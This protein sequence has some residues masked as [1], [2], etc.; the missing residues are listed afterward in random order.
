MN[1]EE[2]DLNTV[3]GVS[4]VRHADGH[5]YN[6]FQHISED[7]NGDLPPVMVY[8]DSNDSYYRPVE[9]FFGTTFDMSSREVERFIP[10]AGDGTFL[11]NLTLEGVPVVTRVTQYDLADSLSQ[12]IHE[13]SGVEVALVPDILDEYA[14]S[15]EIEYAVQ[16]TSEEGV[17]DDDQET[18]LN[19]LFNIDIWADSDDLTKQILRAFNLK[20]EVAKF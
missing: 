7:G 6:L 18:L 11:W 16:L 1:M 17:P 15:Y 3:K 12:I 5:V 9:D 2:F 10:C 13:E 20:L 14:P 19:D 4:Y 8:Y